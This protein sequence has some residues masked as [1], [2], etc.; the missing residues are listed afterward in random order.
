M[1]KVIVLVLF[2]FICNINLSTQWYTLP[3]PTT[4]NLYSLFFLNSNTG[5]VSGDLFGNIIKTTNGGTFYTTIGTGTNKWY[6]D[7]FFI[8]TQNGFA[9]GQ[10]GAIVKTT[11]GGNNWTVVV[12]TGIFMHSIRFPSSSIGYA[13]GST[14]IFK[15]TNGGNN[16]IQLSNPITGYLL[17]VHFIND[18]TGFVCG[19][20]GNIGKTINGGTSWTVTTTG[21]SDTYEEVSFTDINTGYIAGKNGKILKTINTG[22]SWQTLVTPTTEWLFDIFML[23]NNTGWA[24][25]NNGVIIN[26]VNGGINWII[27]PSGITN[28]IRQIHFVDANTGYSVTDGGKIL[29]TTNG[30]SPLGCFTKLTSDPVMNDNAW[31]EGSAW[32]DYDNDG[33]QDL[34]VTNYNDG[35]QTCNY[36]LL[37][38]R[39][40]GGNFTKITTGPIATE[41]TRGFGASWGDYN[42]DG[43]L[44]LFVSTGFGLNNLLFH[45]D[46]G[47]NF[48]KITS[49]IIVNDGGSSTASSW[50]DYNRDGW[51]DMFVVNLYSENDFLYRNN[52]NGTF[53]KITSDPITNDGSNGRGCAVGDYNNDGWTDIFVIC[54]Q[55]QADRLYKNNGNGTFSLM[56]GSVPIDNDWG[57]GGAFGDYDNDGWLDLFVTNHNTNNRLYR[58]NGN[59]SFSLATSSLP[60]NESGPLSFGC[61][62]A[63]FDNDGKLDLFVSNFG[64]VSFLYKNNGGSSFS[65]VTNESIA[66]DIAFGVGNSFSDINMDGKIDFFVANNGSGSPLND[67]L[68]VNNCQQSGNYLGIKLKGCTLNKS[69]IGS[70]IRIKQ[71]SNSYIREGTGGQGYHGQNSLWELFG[72]GTATTVDS[73]IVYWTTGNIQKFTN[74]SANQYIL[75]DE[76]LVGLVSNTS[77]VP[78]LFSLSQNYPNPFNPSTKIKFALPNSEKVLLEIF[79]YLGKSITTLINTDLKTGYYEYEYDGSALSSGVYF[80]RLTTDNFVDT[81]KMVLVK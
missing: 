41:N 39:N 81:R 2:A 45:N 31:G 47:G 24:C 12:N 53:T 28:S 10:D 71:G 52:G 54:Y 22:T 37:L 5:I 15:S 19:D 66:T 40:N 34:I 29:K 70:R 14:G 56:N 3:Q 59:G 33:D 64:T 60:N 80:Y 20:M 4:N 50:I 30:S 58:N 21:G 43:R 32:G 77:E 42:N 74:I 11:N 26:T 48:T 67:L 23:N 57:S 72:L 9:C 35:C 13:A 51:L 75:I 46:G 18:L 1:K 62:W 44:D 25:G 65:R 27:Q 78:T 69:G 76:C 61:V 49:G 63:D 8:D 79:D 7:I 6:L 73:V 16:W 17:G 68:Y 55:G 36:P 38:Y